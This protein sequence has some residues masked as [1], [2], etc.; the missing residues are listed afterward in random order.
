MIKHLTPRSEEE[1]KKLD[2]VEKEQIL[3]D[4]FT[5]ANDK[6]LTLWKQAYINSNAEK[7]YAEELARRNAI[8]ELNYIKHTPWYE[9][10]NF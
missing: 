4:I 6:I 2:D 3:K 9:H 8:K 7:V 1:I 10:R 5:I